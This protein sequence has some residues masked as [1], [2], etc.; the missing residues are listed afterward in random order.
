MAKMSSIGFVG[1]GIMGKGMVKNLVTKIGTPMVVWNRSPEVCAEIKEQYGD[2][3]TIASTA[4]DVVKSCPVT[5]CM[6]STEEASVAVFDAPD[7]VIAGVSEGKIIVDCA[8]LSAERMI[9]ESTRILAKGGRFI[10]A[11][12]SGSKGP[13]ETG[14]LIFL[15]GGLQETYEAVAE[16]LNAMG[17]AKF[18]FGPV[19]KGTEVKLIVN[20]IMGTMMSAF[21][22]GLSL[23][24]SSDIPLEQLL[25]VLDLGAMSNP[26]FRLKGPN[27]MAD[28]HPTNFPLKHQQKD[29][30]LALDLASQKGV[31]L[32]TSTA[33]NDQYLK[34]MAA[35]IG[36]GDEDFS[37]VM[38]AN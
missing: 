18:L 28:T 19:G 6:L 2:L 33:A 31:V 20:M 10:E 29:M 22:E 25:E 36:A 26:M 30:R 34:A 11:P 14:A 24:K 3:I 32:P 5:Y 8:T 13:A 9:D 15:C 21:A 23:G 37:A 12:V 35:P 7:G 1:L 17:K 16:G 38:K 27:M 4:A